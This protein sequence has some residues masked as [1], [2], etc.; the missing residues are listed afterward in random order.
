MPTLRGY[1]N[2]CTKDSVSVKWFQ[3]LESRS[4][5]RAAGQTTR[6]KPTLLK[7]RVAVA[8][9]RLERTHP[10]KS[11]CQPQACKDGGFHDIDGGICPKII[12][13]FYD[14]HGQNKLFRSRLDMMST[15]ISFFSCIAKLHIMPGLCS[16]S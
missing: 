7:K 16:P 1:L 15:V 2:I 12:K 9:K 6:R 10:R 5:T 13:G 4:Q 11:G 3:S 14:L 8:P